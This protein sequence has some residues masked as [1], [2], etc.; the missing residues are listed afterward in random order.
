MTDDG[1]NDEV[2]SNGAG[3]RGTGTRLTSGTALTSAQKQRLVRLHHESRALLETVADRLSA[4]ELEESR[5]LSDAGE[6]GELVNGLCAHLVREQAAVTP[7]ERDGLASVLG[8]M[9]GPRKQRYRYVD[10]PEGTLAALDVVDEPSGTA[11]PRRPG[12]GRARH[13]RCGTDER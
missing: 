12:G 8:L 4:Q 2:D 3:R 5:S 6:W 7:A 9:F 1:T 11:A 13:I 10:D